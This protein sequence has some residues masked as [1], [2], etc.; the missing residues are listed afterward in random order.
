MKKFIWITA[1]IFIATL[2]GCKDNGSYNKV[3]SESDK[4]V[5]FTKYKTFSWLPDVRDTVNSPYNNEII[6]N[7]IRNYFG[8]C[9]SDRGYSFNAVNPDLLM[10]LIITNTKTVRT[11]SD[12]ATSYYYSPYYYGSTYYSPY[13]YG[14]YYNGPVLHNNIDYGHNSAYGR[15]FNPTYV[16]GSISLVFIDSKTNK[17]VW[18]G[19]AEGDI[20]DPA[21]INMDLHPAVHSI[22]E[23][24]PVKPIVKRSHKI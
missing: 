9:M 6:R 14:Y 11:I 2:V 8:L 12:H 13:Q 22:I 24:Y 1:A 21:N 18:R 19:T 20:N 23:Q 4:T 3:S 7:N 15:T 17:I 5:D 10:Q 16:N